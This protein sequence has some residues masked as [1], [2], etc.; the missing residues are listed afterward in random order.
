[1]KRYDDGLGELGRAL[2]LDPRLAN[3][4]YKSLYAGAYHERAKNEIRDLDY[5]RAIADFTEALKMFPTKWVYKQGLFDAYFARGEFYSDKIKDPDRAL[6]DFTEAM[7][8]IPG[9]VRPYMY[10]GHEY[11]YSKK[12]NDRA[13]ADFTQV[14]V[15]NPNEDNAYIARGWAYRAKGDKERARA[16]FAEGERLRKLQSP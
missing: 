3:S 15:L 13:I 16:D 8:V 10:R 5:D 4:F 9:D 12:D 6:A 2:A 14:L 11:F 1:M 7:R